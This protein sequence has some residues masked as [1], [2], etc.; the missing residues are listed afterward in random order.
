MFWNNAKLYDVEAHIAEIYDQGV[1]HTDDIELIQK[2]IAKR[3]GLQILEP[4]CGT[5]RILIPLAEDGHTI[6]GIDKAGGMLARA[7]TKVERLSEEIQG[8]ISLIETDAIEEEWPCGFDVVILGGNCFY[9]LAT[10]AEQEKCIKSAHFSLKLGGHIFIDNNHMEGDLDQTWQEPGIK[11]SFPTGRCEDGT[12]VESTMEIEWY[13]VSQRLAR[14]R[15]KTKVT[16]PDG[17]MI[18]AC[19]LYTSDAADD[20][21]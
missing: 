10:P 2:L 14:F 20:L 13:D 16:L 1:T 19:L 8:R 9:K 3:G 4:F 15:R 12:I 6:V 18:E 17:A 11:Q 7:K 5:G 21:A